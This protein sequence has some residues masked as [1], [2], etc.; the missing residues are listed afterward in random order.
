MENFLNL[1][2]EMY[3]KPQEAQRIP[4]T[5]DPKRPTPRH[6]IIKV[7]KVKY[8]E[9]ILKAAGEKQLPTGEHA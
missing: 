6:I 7:P 3:L 9:R 1:V 5:R 2:K 4:K 8:E